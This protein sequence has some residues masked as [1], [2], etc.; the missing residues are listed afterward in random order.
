LAKIVCP[1]TP[2]RE[3]VVGKDDF[4]LRDQRAV[5]G[6][7]LPLT[8]AKLMRPLKEVSS[9]TDEMDPFLHT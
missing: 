7:A 8:A 9:L 5:N 4:V 3:V 2:S 6:N 1:V